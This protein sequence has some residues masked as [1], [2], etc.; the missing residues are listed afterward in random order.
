MLVSREMRFVTAPRP[1]DWRDP[2]PDMREV[3][4]KLFLL[5]ATF[6]FLL[7]FAF[8]QRNGISAFRAQ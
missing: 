8:Q 2:V 6:A 4:S 5:F 7:P 3:R 1:L